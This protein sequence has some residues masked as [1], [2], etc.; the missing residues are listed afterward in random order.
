MSRR[1]AAPLS[2]HPIAGASSNFLHWHY[3]QKEM[4]D[5]KDPQ[6]KAFAS[7]TLPML[8]LHL[9]RIQSIAAAAGIEKKQKEGNDLATGPQANKP[10][11]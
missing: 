5:G 8:Q 6:A 4:A 11:S 9:Q 2:F 1:G 10:Q 3:F 7:A